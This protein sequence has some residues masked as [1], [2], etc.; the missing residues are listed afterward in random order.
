MM[1]YKDE[2]S[3]A[4]R[5]L[6]LLNVQRT[7]EKVAEMLHTAYFPFCL[8]PPRHDWEFWIVEFRN[9]L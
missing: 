3:P 8:S 5:G 7:C 9:Q 1:G 4:T 6:I 2:R